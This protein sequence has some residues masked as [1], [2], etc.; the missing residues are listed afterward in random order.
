MSGPNYSHGGLDEVK[1]RLVQ[2]FAS[3]DIEQKRR[4]E[5][6]DDLLAALAAAMDWNWLDD[7]ARPSRTADICDAAIAKASGN[8]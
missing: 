1:A 2:R 6:Y 3:D 7:D 5:C 4:A 8:V